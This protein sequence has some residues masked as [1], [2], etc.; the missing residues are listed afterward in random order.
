M[1]TSLLKKAALIVLLLLIFW[2]YYSGIEAVPFHP[3]ESTQ[4]FMSPDAVANPMDLAYDPELK[5]DN[6]TRYRLIDAPVTRFLIGWGLSLQ[7]KDPNPVDWD[8]TTSWDDNLAAGALP[9]TSTL[10][11]ARVS[12]AWLFPFSCLFLFLLTRKICNFPTAILVVIL[13][14]TN[15]L[16]LLHTRR[17][18]AESALICM[19][20]ALSWLMVDFK[21]A[22]W[23]TGLAAG[24][25]ANTKQTALPAALLGAFEAFL[26]PFNTNFRKKIV[27]VGIFLSAMLVVTIAINPVFWQHPWEAIREGTTQRADLSARMQADYKTSGNLL[28]QSIILIAHT[29]IQPPAAADVLNYQEQTQ[30][31]EDAYFHFPL[32]N[33]FRGFAGGTILFILTITGWIILFRKSSHRVFVEQTQFFVFSAITIISIFSLLVFTA[34]P[35]QRYY[36]ILIPLF[37]IFQATALHAIGLAILNAIKKRAAR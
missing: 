20:C 32:N 13:F 16:I 27:R 30:A 11:A 3:D 31:S 2:N 29:F 26:L 17:A 36:I 4:I 7:G 18:M 25:A 5:L 6:R 9:A 34:A 14:S 24:L 21:R 12:V 28:Q 10:L 33:L 19:F 35:F 8:W 37:T 1:K 15:A 22:V 23:V